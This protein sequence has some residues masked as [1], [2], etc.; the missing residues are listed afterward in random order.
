[1]KCCK[2][3]RDLKPNHPTMLMVLAKIKIK[4]KY[5][6]EAYDVLKVAVDLYPKN[7]NVRSSMGYFYKEQNM[8]FEAAEEFMEALRLDQNN[9]SAYDGLLGTLM[10]TEQFEEANKILKN[11]EKKN[12]PPFMLKKIIID[13]KVG[14]KVNQE[15]LLLEF[16]SQYSDKKDQDSKRALL[17]ANLNLA[18]LRY[19][20]GNSQQGITDLLKF[21]NFQDSIFTSDILNTFMNLSENTFKYLWLLLVSLGSPITGLAFME[22]RKK[23]YPNLNEFWYNIALA[24]AGISK[25]VVEYCKYVFNQVPEEDNF[26]FYLKSFALIR[27]N[28]K[29]QNV[30]IIE[31][32]LDQI[33][34]DIKDFKEFS[35]NKIEKMRL[36]LRIQ[37]FEKLEEIL[38]KDF[39]SMVPDVK[40]IYI[41]FL[42]KKKN[43]IFARQALGKIS[44]VLQE[45]PNHPVYLYIRLSLYYLIG[46]FSGFEELYKEF[47][48]KTF[49]YLLKKQKL[50]LK[51]LMSKWN[52]E[53]TEKNLIKYYELIEKFKDWKLTN[54]IPNECMPIEKLKHRYYYFYCKYL[55]MKKDYDE[56]YKILN[57]KLFEMPL[58]KKIDVVVRIIY[59]K[60]GLKKALKVAEPILT[61][62][63]SNEEFYQICW[64]EVAYVCSLSGLIQQTK[65]ISSYYGTVRFPRLEILHFLMKISFLVDDYESLESYVSKIEDN[66]IR[67]HFKDNQELKSDLN[68]FNLATSIHKCYLLLNESKTSKSKLK[69]EIKNV[70]DE[71]KLYFYEIKTVSSDLN[72]ERLFLKYSETLQI[73]F[74]SEFH[75]KSFMDNRRIQ[76]IYDKGVSLY[77]KS[78]TFLRLVLKLEYTKKNQTSYIKTLSDSSE[79][80]NELHLLAYK[81]LE[82][83]DKESLKILSTYFKDFNFSFYQDLNDDLNRIFNKILTIYLKNNRSLNI[84]EMKALA[85]VYSSKFSSEEK[86]FFTNEIYRAEQKD[87]GNLNG[88]F[89]ELRNLFEQSNDQYLLEF[90]NIL[91]Q[92]PEPLYQRFL[93]KTHLHFLKKSKLQKKDSKHSFLQHNTLEFFLEWV[94]KNSVQKI[95]CS[96][97]KQ[98]K[99][100]KSQ[101]KVISDIPIIWK[102]FSYLLNIKDK[103]NQEIINLSNSL[104]EVFNYSEQ[105]SIQFTNFEYYFHDLNLR[106]LDYKRRL[107][108]ILSKE[109]KLIQNLFHFCRELYLHFKSKSEN[110][111]QLFLKYFSM[112]LIEVKKSSKSNES[113]IWKEIMKDLTEQE[114][115]SEQSND[116][117]LYSPSKELKDCDWRFYYECFLMNYHLYLTSKEMKYLEQNNILSII[118]SQLIINE[119]AFFNK[120]IF[121]L[122]E[123]MK[124]LRDNNY[125]IQEFKEKNYD[126]HEILKFFVDYFSWNQ[127]NSQTPFYHQ[128]NQELII[129]LCIKNIFPLILQ[130]IDV[131]WSENNPNIIQLSLI[132]ASFM[133]IGWIEAKDILQSKYYTQIFAKCYSKIP[134]EHFYD[135]YQKELFND[136]Q[137]LLDLVFYAQDLDLS[138]IHPDYKS[139]LLYFQ[140][141]FKNRESKMDEFSL[142]L[143]SILKMKFENIQNVK[144][145][146]KK[147]QMMMDIELKNNEVINYE[148]MDKMSFESEDFSSLLCKTLSPKEL[149]YQDTLRIGNFYFQ[150][151]TKNTTFSQVVAFTKMNKNQA[152]FSSWFESQNTES[153]LLEWKT[154]TKTKAKKSSKFN[155]K[156][157]IF[158]LFDQSWYQD[159]EILIRE[160]GIWSC[161]DWALDISNLNFENLIID[162]GKKSI[163]EN[164]INFLFN[165]LNEENNKYRFT[166][167]IQNLC[168]SVNNGK[169]I[170]E[171]AFKETL[172]NLISPFVNQRLVITIHILLTKDIML[173]SLELVEKQIEDNIILLYESKW[174]QNEPV[175]PKYSTNELIEKIS[176]ERSDI[177]LLKMLKKKLKLEKKIQEKLGTE[178]SDQK[179]EIIKEKILRKVHFPISQ[180]KLNPM[181]IFFKKF[182]GTSLE[183]KHNENV[184]KIYKTL[185]F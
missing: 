155:L 107:F 4:L 112:K 81:C 73:Y 16:C 162:L 52:L 101:E 163:Y 157:N 175:Y 136:L 128:P 117:Y 60:D 59:H 166:E 171:K 78:K 35:A 57:G 63:N 115:P 17:S 71:M 127:P 134:K 34:P 109:P 137:F 149:I 66:I 80:L 141:V 55:I 5:P 76:D 96:T 178:K 142:H 164:E 98:A 48:P 77:P 87:R 113:P 28:E 18:F 74:D 104:L 10:D 176:N 184:E 111:Y 182:S 64:R 23:Y 147:N 44:L 122:N 120:E 33:L 11:L 7:S 110:W 131:Y 79:R 86:E 181:E 129:K 42:Y 93:F 125:K 170:F 88:F 156:V 106:D 135:L 3:A 130:L 46:D 39:N 114:I 100:E 29:I 146:H 61:P 183:K 118:I 2:I 140:S 26:I 119:L 62:E 148:Y 9:L 67:Q 51:Y 32:C 38:P 161:I 70:I 138:M 65:S 167:E 169:E 158:Q 54:Q 43:L 27:Q 180:L 19:Q 6:N 150:A 105:I 151:K 37:D 90:E 139:D 126:K 45:A 108:K 92:Y 124:H 94:M 179:L 154:I 49:E 121:E 133:K 95:Q 30:N 84:H 83:D 12:Y 102:E 58:E 13:E 103:S 143:H 91:E 72:L 75:E 31:Q 68:I 20:N 153:I 8:N 36:Y 123:K 145:Y 116:Y 14:K 168:K 174:N 89:D 173:P 132:V 165:S 185:Q 53:Q 152:D 144:I 40:M 24:E 177:Y 1:M 56:C 15:K 85:L 50:Y 22:R 159:I 82:L 25:E 21:L 41:K 99:R 160:L 97:F 47:N 69:K 172:S